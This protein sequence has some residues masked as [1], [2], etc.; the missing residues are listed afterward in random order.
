MQMNMMC[1]RR[2]FKDAQ[3]RFD[4]MT[5]VIN[6]YLEG[7]EAIL[8]DLSRHIVERTGNSFAAMDSIMMRFDGLM[9]GYWLFHKDLIKFKQCSYRYS[10]LAILQSVDYEDPMPFFFRSDYTNVKEP[11]FHM[12]MSDSTQIRDFL[13][14]NI[15]E[16]ANDT[17]DLDDEY[18]LNCQMIYNTLLMLE[19]KQ[20]ERLKQRSL[21]VLEAPIPQ[22]K[23]FVKELELRK[24]DFHFY[25]AFAEQDIDGMKKALEPFFT[26][27]IAQD[28]A[29]HTLVYF[30]FYLQ[31]QVLVYA[32]LASMHGFDLGIDHEIAPK[33]L[34]QYQP[35]P[36]E[37]Y[38]DIVDFMKPY[39]LS[40]PYEYLQ[41]WIDYYTHKTDQL[42]PLA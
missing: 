18:D 5:M 10:K 26:K 7:G 38:Q 34:I 6:S 23:Q 3:Q 22:V 39:K 13:V 4:H 25:V 1:A 17:E 9:S 21:K 36:E 24:Y 41:N 30:D 28:A 12:L 29:K 14:R 31:P 37:E 2:E 32:K 33:E 19:G 15:E 27:K 16:V 11:M 40:Y 35:L 20:L 42:F 8:F